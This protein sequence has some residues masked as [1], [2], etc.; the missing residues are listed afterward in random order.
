MSNTFIFVTVSDVAA[1][2]VELNIV[3]S[4]IVAIIEVKTFFIQKP[5][6][7]VNITVDYIRFKI[8]LW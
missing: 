5:P 1:K 3:R 7:C 4:I 6:F 8:A 2:A